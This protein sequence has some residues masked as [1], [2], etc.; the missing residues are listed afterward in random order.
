M[1]SFQPKASTHH[2][3]TGREE[4]NKG[5]YL[6][7]SSVTS[8]F[9]MTT[10]SGTNCKQQKKDCKT[11]NSEKAAVSAQRQDK[12]CAGKEENYR[13]RPSNRGEVSQSSLSLSSA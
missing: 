6:A 13:A 11:R 5:Y 12:Q 9:V 7:S 1:L 10:C 8:S 2:T 4:T 3:Q